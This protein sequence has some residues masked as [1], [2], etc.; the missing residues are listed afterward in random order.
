[1][2]DE[3]CDFL[4]INRARKEENK[5]FK[6]EKSSELFGMYRS[7]MIRAIHSIYECKIY[8]KTHRHV[9][10]HIYVATVIKT[11]NRVI[12]SMSIILRMRKA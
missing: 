12:R 7:A 8:V 3:L 5:K 9:F 2:W 10:Y 6:V 4:P 11:T 1:M